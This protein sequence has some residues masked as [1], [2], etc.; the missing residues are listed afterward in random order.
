[1][2]IAPS[3]TQPSNC[4]DRRKWTPEED[5]L[6]TRA[7]ARFRHM[8]EIRWTEIAA[9]IPERSAK[10]CRKRWVNGLNERLKKGSWT[11]EEDGRLREGV[12]ML[13]SD[14]ARIADHVGQR[15]GDQCSKRW[16]EVL[17]PA[18]NKS[19]WTAE[20]DQLLTQLFHKHGSSWQVIS[21]HFNNRRALQCRN[22]CCKLLGL[23]S[24]PRTKKSPVE[25]KGNISALQSPSLHV[26]AQGEMPTSPT[27]I[28]M[29]NSMWPGLNMPAAHE[30]MS[31]AHTFVPDQIFNG[32]MLQNHNAS[33]ACISPI[34]PLFNQ[35]CNQQAQGSNMLENGSSQ[36]LTSLDSWNKVQGFS[37][38][39][40]K[41]P[42]AALNLSDP[43]TQSVG[44][45]DQFYSPFFASPS[46]CSSISTSPTTPSGTDTLGLQ[47]TSNPSAMLPSPIV[48]HQMPT[49][50]NDRLSYAAPTSAMPAE[51]NMNAMNWNMYCD[52]LVSLQTPQNPSGHDGMF[53]SMMNN[54][55]PTNPMVWLPDMQF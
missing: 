51:K 49:Q 35:G 5:A 10:A 23:H 33:Q 52:K 34:S 1:M 40:R 30:P 43:I 7:M 16:R 2:V 47:S 27:Y 54:A 13:S 31:G 24:Y 53:S 32:N 39:Q 38:L 21:T 11:N 45:H 14:W 46:L 50:M 12:A 8:Q 20:E 4:V 25:K 55:T 3:S 22:R 41:D 29:P 19:S 18:I 36:G 37:S 9:E 28:D 48:Q 26:S 42:P 15:S 17:D 44:G 6:L